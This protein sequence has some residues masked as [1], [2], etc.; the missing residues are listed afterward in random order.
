MPSKTVVKAQEAIKASQLLDMVAAGSSVR[1]ASKQLGIHERTGQRLYHSELQ[2]YY[3]EN[4]AAREELVG[5]ELRTLDLLQRR[6]MQ[7]ALKGDARAVDRVLQ[8]MA[9]RSKMLG[10]DAAAKISVE[11]SRVD[12]ALAEIVQ[13]IDGSVAASHTLERLLPEAG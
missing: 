5:R 11:V 3:Q 9:Q 6:M 4:A 13:I 1:A 12:D 2:R 10:L 7:D 8:I